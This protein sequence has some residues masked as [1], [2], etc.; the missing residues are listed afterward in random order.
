MWSSCAATS[1]WNSPQ[2]LAAQLGPRGRHV[3]RGQ[4]RP[5]AL[6]VDGHALEL[7]VLA[8]EHLGE[9]GIEAREHRDHLAVLV[10][11]VLAQES[12]A[13]ADALHGGTR[14]RPWR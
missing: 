6:D 14:P 1:A 3:E 10:L 9:R 2:E 5:E 13:G 8:V 11:R 12:D 7:G 4:A